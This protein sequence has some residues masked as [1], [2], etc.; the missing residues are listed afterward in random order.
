MRTRPRGQHGGTGPWVRAW[1]EA[2][3][4]V[5]GCGLRVGNERGQISVTVMLPRVAFEYGQ[6]SW[7][8]STRVRAVPRS[9]F[10]MSA[11]ISTMIP[12]PSPFLPGL[13]NQWNSGWR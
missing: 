13:G 5:Q 6:T 3:P 1:A 2:A 12:K 7:A 10:G 8:F 11:E 4:H 9:T